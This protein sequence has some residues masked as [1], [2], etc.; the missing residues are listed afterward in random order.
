MNSVDILVKTI[1]E[2]ITL[3]KLA[4]I[5]NFNKY[6]IS[7]LLNYK[8]F[9]GLNNYINN[10]RVYKGRDL[11]FKTNKNINEISEII[12]FSSSAAFI[13]KFKEIFSYTPSEY[14]KMHE[15]VKED[16][17][18]AELEDD[19]IEIFLKIIWKTI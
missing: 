6:Y 10:I 4:R 18:Y 5:L 19:N 1:G 9:G 11:L 3:D 8:G 16:E 2:K 17:I 14:R 13:K 12:G 7:H 15:I